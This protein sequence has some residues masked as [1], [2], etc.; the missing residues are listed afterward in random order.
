MK[1]FAAL[2]EVLNTRALTSTA[3]REIAPPAG[4]SGFQPF[5]A[6]GAIAASQE[7]GT[8]HEEPKIELVQ[9]DG[10]VEQII[11]T[12]RCGERTVLDCAY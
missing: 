1:P 3:S 4:A 12:C 2:D 9:Q 5:C 6:P 10:R 8:A 11:V 7:P